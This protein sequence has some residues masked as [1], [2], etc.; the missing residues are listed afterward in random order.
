M[1][2]RRVTK[3][4]AEEEGMDSDCHCSKQ[5]LQ[6]STEKGCRTLRRGVKPRQGGHQWAWGRGE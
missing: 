4:E 2:A 6:R 3:F 5:E 1:V